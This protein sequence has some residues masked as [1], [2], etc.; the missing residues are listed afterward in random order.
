MKNNRR[1]F[2]A[3]GCF[4]ALFALSFALDG[5]ALDVLEEGQFKVWRV[6]K[7]IPFAAHQYYN[8][9][10]WNA[11]GSMQIFQGRQR[12]EYYRLDS[13]DSVPQAFRF[14]TGV[15]VYYAEWSNVDPNILYFAVVQDG[16][17]LLCRK[18]M[19]TGKEETLA[20]FDESFILNNPPH[21]DGKHIIIGAANGNK[22]PVYI[23][24]V[25][26]GEK[27]RFDLTE[28]AHRVGFVNDAKLSFFYNTQAGPRRN[29]IVDYETGA[30]SPLYAGPSSHPHW[31]ATGDYLSFFEYGRHI[32]IDPKGETITTSTQ[33]LS[34]HQSWVGASDYCIM[35]ITNKNSLAPGYIALLNPFT[36]DF[37]LVAPHEAEYG[38][39]QYTHPHVCCSPDGTKAVYNSRNEEG[40]PEVR[41]AQIARPAKALHAKMT[42]DGGS[43]HFTWE[44][45][46]GLE[47][48]HFEIMAI[49]N[50]AGSVLATVDKA[51][52]RFDASL[53]S[54]ADGYAIV[55]CEY[56]GLKSEPAAFESL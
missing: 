48:K 8:T 1:R 50:G 19:D 55:T 37:R 33:Q 38:K 54:Q 36:G 22:A 35:D 4:G 14:E 42:A 29:Y 39:P 16:K 30:I 23:C 44:S 31:N 25:E 52:T 7:G 18:L 11:N 56:S 40:G 26:T 41:V 45:P 9:P 10:A 20:T 12:N 13:L 51:Q 2:S 24:N 32:V 5:F 27:K 49:K 47:I 34:G 21:P 3:F 6:S 43:L 17:T 28:A 46:A 15:P 53:D